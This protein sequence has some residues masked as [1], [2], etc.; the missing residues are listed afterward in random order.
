MHDAGANTPE[1]VVALDAAM[2]DRG[3]LGLVDR[4]GLAR[5][6]PR[7]ELAA[8]M[9][10]LPEPLRDVDSARFDTGVRPALGAAT[11]AY[12]NDA[13]VVA[14]Q[15]DTGAADAAVLLRPVSVATIRAA[16]AAGVRMPEKTTFFAPEAAHRHGDP[17]PRRT[18]AS[19]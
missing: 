9:A 16:A 8:A 13:R 4:A 1:G 15:V 7:P 17:Q 12:R 11:L 6:E 19:S 3:A 10:E 5:L 2:H 14:A 18:V